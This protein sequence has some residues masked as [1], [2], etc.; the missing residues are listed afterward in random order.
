MTSQGVNR[1]P[2]KVQAIEDMPTPKDQSDLQRI[3]GLVTYMSI[4]IPNMSNRTREKDAD[5]QWLPEHEK[6]WQ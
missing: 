2:E 5:W 6:A 3:L 1:D 4:L